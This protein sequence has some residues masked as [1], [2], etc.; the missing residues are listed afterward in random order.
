MNRRI[1]QNSAFLIALYYAQPLQR[2]FMIEFISP[3]RIRAISNIAIK[4]VQGRVAVNNIHR[5]KLRHY[6]RTIRFLANQRISTNWKKRTLLAFHDVIP[7][8]IK[9]ILHLLDEQ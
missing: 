4:I 5:Q 6:K 7:L 1:F 3:D 8:L 9:P 2:K